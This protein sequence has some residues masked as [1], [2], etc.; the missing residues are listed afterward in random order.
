MDTHQLNA[1]ITVAESGSFSRAA[2]AMHLT[3]PAISKRIAALEQFLGASLFDRIGK[4]IKL[5]EAGTLLLPRAIKIVRDLDDTRTSI[6]NLNSEVAGSL[7]LAASHH[8][9]LRRL[10]PVLK[11]YS[12]HYPAVKIDIAFLDSEEAYSKILHGEIELAVVTLAI[13]P[14]ER[15]NQ[16]D[17]W[18]DKLCF[19]TSPDHPLASK[20]VISL[21]QLFEYPAI[22][23]GENTFT[24]Q[25]IDQAVEKKN[26]SLKV[27]SSTNYLETIK[28]MVSIGM[29]WSV[30]PETMLDDSIVKIPVKGMEISRHLGYIYHRDHTLSNA[31][32]A[33][34]ELLD[35]SR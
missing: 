9:G 11:K 15:I 34:L 27:E 16:K 8:V 18:H 21:E 33:F 12:K 3:Q 6:Q 17:L 35:I 19:T 13:E 32:Q 20:Q 25:M 7:S 31:A 30:L 2:T 22:L 10:P 29:A 26:L 5:T 28:M 24:R 1:F 23:T 14:H 4:N